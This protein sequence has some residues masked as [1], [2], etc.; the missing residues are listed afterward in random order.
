MSDFLFNNDFLDI[1]DLNDLI[2]D[3]LF[4]LSKD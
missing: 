1:L 3:K 2:Y 4:R